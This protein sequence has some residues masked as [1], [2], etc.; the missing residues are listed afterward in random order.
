MNSEDRCYSQRPMRDTHLQGR[1]RVSVLKQGNEQANQ[2]D[3][4]LRMESQGVASHCA[5]API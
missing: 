2:E 1:L 3:L 4:I 5:P